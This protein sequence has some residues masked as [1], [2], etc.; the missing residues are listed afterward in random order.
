MSFSTYFNLRPSQKGHLPLD[1]HDQ[2]KINI[3]RRNFWLCAFTTKF[4]HHLA[5]WGHDHGMAIA[6]PLLI[7]F[8]DLSS[9]YNICLSFNGSCSQKRLPMCSPSWDCER[10][11]ISD[12]LTILPCQR[13]A[14]LWK[15]KLYRNLAG[16][17]N[18]W[19]RGDFHTSKQIISPT[20]PRAVSKGGSIDDPFSTPLL[21]FN[22][23]PF[24]MSTSKRWSFW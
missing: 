1:P 24:S 20:L 21:S 16:W 4:C 10:W 3:C 15:T 19:G 6:N 14:D 23:G 8:A 22:T 7:V 18:Q 9:G 2:L 17:P 12:N 11:W 5:P 13:E